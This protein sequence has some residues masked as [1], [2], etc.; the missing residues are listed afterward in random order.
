MRKKKIIMEKFCDTCGKEAFDTCLCCGKDFCISHAKM[1][2]IEY[3]HSV[4]FGGSDD[5]FFCKECDV[6]LTN[7][8]VHPLYRLHEA[9]KEISH[10]R[11]EG[12]EYCDKLEQ[13]G[14]DA[15]KQLKYWLKE[16]KK[17][18]KS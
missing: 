15:E 7:N 2:G 8:S 10:L 14:D 17:I 12:K 13:R 11:N 9:Y 16:T 3:N 6:E 5:G 1:L 4:N 18:V